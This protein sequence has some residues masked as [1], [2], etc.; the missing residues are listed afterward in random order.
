MGQPV[1]L[2]EDFVTDLKSSTKIAS[3]G[4]RFYC[5]PCRNIPLTDLMED[6]LVRDP[7]PVEGPHLGSISFAPSHHP[8]PGSILIPALNPAPAS[9]LA[10]TNELFKKFMKTYLESNQGPRQPPAECK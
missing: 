6:E 1:R 9:T 2:E 3:G 5:S 8:T 10:S 4:S 7:S